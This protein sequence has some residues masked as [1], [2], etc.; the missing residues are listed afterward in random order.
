M[1]RLN[2]RVAVCAMLSIAA[3]SLRASASLIVPEFNS[4]PTLPGGGTTFAK[5]YLDFDG[6]VTPTWGPYSPGTTI[7]YDID[8]D[9]NN[10]SAAELA[11][12]HTIWSGVAEK[13]SP[14]KINVTTKDPGNINNNE[15]M[16][17]VIGGSGDWAP[18]GSGGI[19]GLNSYMN[20]VLPNVAFVFPGHLAN[21]NPRYVAEASAH[22]TGHALGL[23]HQSVWDASLQNRLLEY[24][25]GDGDRAP[26]MGVSYYSTRG[27]WWKGN[28][29][30]QPTP[31]QD[32][33]RLI[34]A[35]GTFRPNFGYRADDHANV[36]TSAD[37]L[38]V[39]V[40][41]DITGSGVIELDTD[42][43]FFSFTSPG[44]TAY[45][46]ADVN[47]EAPMLDLSLSLY[48]SGGAPITTAATAN[49]GEW[50]QVELL[51]GNY[52][53]SVNSAGQYGDIGQYFITGN[54]V[55]EPASA[56]AFVALLT[57]P[58]RRRRR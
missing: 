46:R 9:A 24:N 44:G 7:A 20:S 16:K 33:L 49:L 40:D 3:L 12:I 30:N 31:L 1:L 26:I 45:I 56:A 51:A 6:D 58:L 37:P 55:P 11:N 5:L 23:H 54:V 28:P 41:F 22:E 10:F 42:A 17:I 36:Y 18:A 13:Y 25:P 27:M 14:F 52:F 43:D 21:G 29:D 35:I 34:S 15:T 53:V 38:A 50:M 2:A 39:D 47:P 8:G 19:A 57:L 48:D 4:Y 32:D